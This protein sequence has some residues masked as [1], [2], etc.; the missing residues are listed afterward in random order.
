[1][2]ECKFLECKVPNKLKK[3]NTTIALD[4]TWCELSLGLFIGLMSL[5]LDLN[6]WTNIG[7]KPK[8]NSHWTLT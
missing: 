1:M 2:L 5:Y 7:E 3:I 6:F 8:E 4:T